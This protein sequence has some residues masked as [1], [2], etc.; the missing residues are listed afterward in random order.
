MLQSQFKLD[1]QRCYYNS[2]EESYKFFGILLFDAKLVNGGMWCGMATPQ[3]ASGIK[4]CK[5][6]LQQR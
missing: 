2:S 4:D 3:N 5:T 6:T 1:L